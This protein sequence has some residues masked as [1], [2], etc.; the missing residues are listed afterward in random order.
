MKIDISLYNV[1]HMYNFYG[2]SL[3]QKNNNK[4][5]NNNKKITM[6]QLWKIAET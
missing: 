2:I 1:F 4:K 6:E 3:V 5:N